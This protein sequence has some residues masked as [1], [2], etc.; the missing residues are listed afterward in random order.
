[1]TRHSSIIGLVALVLIRILRHFRPYLLPDI[2]HD[3]PT[4]PQF[5]SSSG[6]NEYIYT[7]SLQ[8]ERLVMILL[9]VWY[10]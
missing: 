1:M 8:I 4:E 5:T 10:M 7:Y 2:D 6:T 3:V 9:V